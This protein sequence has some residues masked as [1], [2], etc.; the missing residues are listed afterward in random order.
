MSPDNEL[1]KKYGGIKT[2]TAQIIK[3]KGISSFW[4]TKCT[5]HVFE[6]IIFGWIF[7]IL[8]LFFCL[9][10]MSREIERDVTSI[11]NPKEHTRKVNIFSD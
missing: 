4:E 10:P 3:G 7:T 8:F 9:H 1:T 11:T 2:K 6:E 5:Q